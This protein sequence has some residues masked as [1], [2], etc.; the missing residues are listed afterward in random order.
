MSRNATLRTSWPALAL[1]AAAMLLVGALWFGLAAPRRAFGQIPDSGA[2]RAK[3]I[4]ELQS[5]NKK[6]GEIAGLLRQIREQR[7]ED[8][9][10][11]KKKKTP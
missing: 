1:G 3:M 8:A 6:L 7:S 11:A 9:K 2:Q 10:E 5:A 4:E